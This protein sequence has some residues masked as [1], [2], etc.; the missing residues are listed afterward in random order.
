[1]KRIDAFAF[2]NNNISSVDIKL[3]ENENCKVIETENYK[4]IIKTNTDT[5]ETILFEAAFDSKTEI[6]LIKK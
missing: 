2:I 1:M 3:N 4:T 5:N 6:N